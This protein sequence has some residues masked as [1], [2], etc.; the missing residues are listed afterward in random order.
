MGITLGVI[1]GGFG[2]MIAGAILFNSAPHASQ[3]S[4]LLGLLS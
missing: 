3:Y 2:F 1:I 4:A